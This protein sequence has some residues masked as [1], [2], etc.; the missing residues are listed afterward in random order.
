MIGIIAGEVIGS[1]YAKSNIEDFTNYA[2]FD[3]FADNTVMSID[4]RDYSEKRY[5]ADVGSVSKRVLEL[6]ASGFEGDSGYSKPVTRCEVL[7]GALVL[8]AA[9]RDA[10]TARA[11]AER[12][13]RRFDPQYGPDIERA[14]ML[15]FTTRTAGPEKSQSVEYDPQVLSSLL[16]GRL[17]P[18]ENGT[19]TVGKGKFNDTYAL[20]AAVYAVNASSS[21]VEAVRRAVALGGDSGA[22]AALAGGLA[23]LR[24]PVSDKVRLETNRHLTDQEIATVQKYGTL[25]EGIKTGTVYT[26]DTDYVELKV[27]S[28]EGHSG[29]YFVPP[30]RP[31]IE[32]AIR[33]VNPDAQTTN[34]QAQFDTWVKASHQ[35][36]DL[37][38]QPLSGTFIATPRPELRTL[39]YRESDS[40]IYSPSTLPQ[41]SMKEFR[42][43]EARV[44]ERTAFQ[45]FREQVREF[46]REQ[47]KDMGIDAGP[48]GHVRFGSAWYV[49][50]ERDRV[51]LMKGDTAYGAFGL[52]RFGRA[53]VDTHVVGGS[54]GGEYLEAA[55]ANQSVF[56]KS[57]G[58][59]EVLMK[60]REKCLDDGVIPDEEKGI[61]LNSTL[62]V[63][64]LNQA[65]LNP[66]YER[67]DRVLSNASKTLETT[68]SELRNISAYIVTD[69]ETLGD[70]VAI[71]GRMIENLEE[72]VNTRPEVKDKLQPI[73]ER[74][75]DQKE[76]LEELSKWREG[77]TL[78]EPVA[79]KPLSE[80][81]EQFTT[82]DN[83]LSSETEP[84][85]SAE[86]ATAL[87]ERL[88]GLKAKMSQT[89]DLDHSLMYSEAIGK[90]LKK[91]DTVIAELKNEGTANTYLIST[92]GF[93]M[94]NTI[95]ALKDPDQH[96]DTAITALEDLRKPFAEYVEYVESLGRKDGLLVSSESQTLPKRGESTAENSYG[97][98]GPVQTVKRDVFRSAH[99]GAVFTI[100]TSN[101]PITD[102]I[103]NLKRN[104]VT[105][106][107][108]V[109]SFT[110][111]SNYPQFERKALQSALED[112]GIRYTYEG[113]ALG[114]SI[115]KS[116]PN[117]F[118]GV[119]FTASEGGYRQRTEENAKAAD[120]TVAFGI[121][122]NTSGEKVTAAAAK[123][124]YAWIGLEDFRQLTEQD[125]RDYGQALYESLSF[126]EKRREME[127]NI[128]GNGI[129][130]FN[131]YG[132]SQQEVNNAVFHVLQEAMDRGMKIRSI[133]SGGQTGADEAGIDAAMKLQIPAH[134]HAPKGYL[135]RGTDSV[136]TRNELAFKA[137]FVPALR[138]LKPEY[139]YSELQSG[140]AYRSALERIATDAQ[141]G[142]R[143]ALMSAEGDPTK[144]HR[145]FSLAFA[146]AHPDLTGQQF[147]PTAVQHIY[148]DG[149]TVA[150]DILE[151]RLCKSAGKEYT[152]ANLKD[153][154][155]QKGEYVQNE[156]IKFR[157]DMARKNAVA[158]SQGKS[159][160][161]AQSSNSRSNGYNSYKSNYNN[162]SRGY[163][164]K[165]I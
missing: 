102:F 78:R 19:Y 36:T 28:Q 97:Q 26:N 163:K 69:R 27:L 48:D 10:E 127:V 146:L 133:R 115:R 128:A 147:E 100:G 151:R 41:A 68:T 64:D 15:A 7:A 2:E 44:K 62:M 72:G 136:D 145:F 156:N 35:Y 142:E 58:A 117:K 79:Q 129:Y 3:L 157:S 155:R 143:Q 107:R 56:N 65:A 73:L 162:A 141:Q 139:S 30:D 164:S 122:P 53:R 96:L 74:L 49:E 130:T 39:Y 87:G 31:E 51:V 81:A 159:Y 82:L 25:N 150:Q 75:R 140:A 138:D 34:S 16:R 148:R 106:V 45:D 103:A 29:Y 21:Y 113:E 85:L 121:D 50:V 158:K 70:Q 42:S 66:T 101:L 94:K 160:A 23:E 37:S 71:L 137:R 55:L 99:K 149:T 60:L 110:N 92:L 125:F 43:V 22:V 59:K 90:S 84:K 24:F 5:R 108:D 17:V 33:A 86:K 13:A 76:R 12:Y 14:A 91:L 52:D 1:P 38:G 88:E 32:S 57:D 105:V 20:D 77:M 135:M 116:I 40:L 4:G 93:E 124:K 8:G 119:M 153:V 9:A 47:E 46:R 67:F 134:V 132:I 120:F 118:E 165:S 98:S 154:M 123:G 89:A 144:S 11:D 126:F 112:V 109:R 95:E 131:Q 6:A 18:N 54:F 111:S 83:E 63:A 161:A 80:L 114:S 61:V 152:D 104:G